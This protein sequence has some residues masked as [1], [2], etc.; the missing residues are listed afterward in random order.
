[1][2]IDYKDLIRN[3]NSFR[4]KEYIEYFFRNI[5][6]TQETPVYCKEGDPSSDCFDISIIKNFKEKRSKIGN[7]Y[8]GKYWRTCIFYC[9]DKEDAYKYLSTSG[10]I[11]YS[12]TDGIISWEDNNGFD[13]KTI[14]SRSAKTVNI[15]VFKHFKKARSSWF[16][17]S[18]VYFVLII[19]D[20]TTPI[21]S[22]DYYIHYWNSKYEFKQGN[23]TSLFG[24]SKG[25]LFVDDVLSELK[26][27]RDENKDA[28]D[29]V[30]AFFGE[31]N[32]FPE[33]EEA[34]AD[35]RKDMDC[36]IPYIFCQGAARTGK[37]VLALRLLHEY[38]DFKLLLMNYNFYV[39]LKDAFGVV[40]HSFPK[41]RIVHHDL[42]H[43]GDGCWVKGV[44]T[45]TLNID[46]THLIVDEA[47]R[48]GKLEETYSFH[49]YHLSGFDSIDTIVNCENHVQTVFFGDDSQ[50]LNPKY[51][52]G[53]GKIKEAILGKDYREYYFSSPLGVPLGL[54]KNVRFLL[55][56]EKS[57]PCSLSNFSFAVE[58]DPAKFIKNYLN[59][60][61]TKKHLVASLIGDIAI[62]RIEIGG[63]SFKNLKAANASRY[64]FN[65]TI[66]K[67]YYLTAYSVISREIESVYLY[68]PKHIYLSD[69]GIIKSK[70]SSDNSFLMNHL[71]TIMTRATMS[72]VICCEDEKLGEYF[73]E[74]VDAIKNEIE[75]ETN[76]D[77]SNFDYDVFIAYFGTD[78]PDGTYKEAKEICNLLKER[79]L[80][81]FLNN[82]SHIEK[83][84][85]LK[86]TET[87]HALYRSETMLFIFNENVDKD[88]SGL[89]VREL[90]DGSTSQIYEEL[91]FFHNLIDMGQRK[92]KYDA[93]FFYTGKRLNKFNIYPFLNNYFPPL[94]QGNSSCCFMNYDDLSEWINARFP[95]RI[96]NDD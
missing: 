81:V 49:G 65:T 5:V 92:T 9:I 20:K 41:D 68:I 96:V 60:T 26:L 48:L 32:F 85:S 11:G 43:K 40:G 77:A 56:F 12:F 28:I 69:E 16:V 54:L 46:I 82:Y 22:K 90:P 13:G 58:R 87:W 21:S 7:A 62:D 72:L 23:K 25:I 4:K 73:S 45:K 79:G 61:Q 6:G 42:K 37:T 36:G 57:A 1:M 30:K 71:Y 91:S 31:L 93:R 17:R 66:Q 75:E 35:V 8:V 39:S 44:G 2:E 63:V 64:L 70:Y 29:C 3:S 84:K 67:E 88:A 55:N 95:L 47:Q 83:D 34:F 51:D 18:F 52:E 78:R 50:M 33:S 76:E 14:D 10:K 38:P 94:T 74:R 89:I 53:I 27:I 59:D 80:S 86:F 24:K 19:C 15:N